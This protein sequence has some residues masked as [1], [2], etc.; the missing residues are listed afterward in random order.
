MNHNDAPVSFRLGTREEFGLWINLNGA[1]VMD[2]DKDL[3]LPAWAFCLFSE[4]NGR[5]A[6]KPHRQRQ[7][8]DNMDRTGSF[9]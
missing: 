6:P 8:E 3:A 4:A 7:D 2:L 9:S 5:V 1:S